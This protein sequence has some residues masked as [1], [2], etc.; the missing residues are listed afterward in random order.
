MPSVRPVLISQ[1]V[2]FEEQDR[3]SRAA[4]TFESAAGFL[5]TAADIYREFKYDPRPANPSTPIDAPM[6]PPPVSL[7]GVNVEPLRQAL[8][9][10][11]IGGFAVALILVARG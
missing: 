11:V 5:R 4:A 8:P 3:E 1:P 2:S 7:G 9:W 6:V 10:L